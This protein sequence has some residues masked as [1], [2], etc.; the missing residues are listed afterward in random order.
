MKEVERLQIKRQ[1]LEEE[2]RKLDA[3]IEDAKTLEELTDKQARELVDSWFI[4]AG[5]Q[6]VIKTSDEYLEG[7]GRIPITIHYLELDE[8]YAHVR[9]YK[10]QSIPAKI[11]RLK[12]VDTNTAVETIENMRQASDIMRTAIAEATESIKNAIE[13]IF[14]QFKGDDA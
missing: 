12:R 7:R 11:A 13:E 9:S 14:S 8:G 5:N 1:H 2:L 10:F 4:D 6:T 3:E